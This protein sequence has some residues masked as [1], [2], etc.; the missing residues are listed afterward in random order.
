MSVGKGSRQARVS[1]RTKS[2]QGKYQRNTIVNGKSFMKG[3]GR[4][5]HS[6][7]KTRLQEGSQQSEKAR[8]TPDLPLPRSRQSTA[9]SPKTGDDASPPPSAGDKR[10]TAVPPDDADCDTVRAKKPC[11]SSSSFLASPQAES[12][13]SREQMGDPVSSAAETE[14]ELMFKKAIR[15]Y[16][17]MTLLDIPS[18]YPRPLYRPF[19]KRNLLYMRKSKQSS[20]KDS[21]E[22]PLLCDLPERTSCKPKLLPGTK[23]EHVSRLVEGI[24]RRN[25]WKQDE[26]MTLDAAVGLDSTQS[27]SNNAKQE[28]SSALNISKPSDKQMNSDHPT[29]VMRFIDIRNK[30]LPGNRHAMITVYTAQETDGVFSEI[31][32]LPSATVQ[33][34][35]NVRSNLVSIDLPHSIGC[36]CSGEKERYDYVILRV[37]FSGEEDAKIS[38]GRTLRSVPSR[39]AEKAEVK[40][41]RRSSN[42]YAP[43]KYNKEDIVT[44]YG[45]RCIS[46]LGDGHINGVI[47]GDGSINLVPEAALRCRNNWRRDRSLTKKLIDLGKKMHMGPFVRMSIVQDSGGETSSSE[48]DDD[49]TRSCS[50]RAES[51]DSF[52][53]VRS[54]FSRQ[55]SV[56]S[57]IE[58]TIVSAVSD[59]FEQF[60]KARYKHEMSLDFPP[61]IC[62]RFIMRYNEEP[63]TSFPENKLPSVPDEPPCLSA[64]APSPVQTNGS[65][66]P[67]KEE[68]DASS[69]KLSPTRSKKPKFRLDPPRRDSLPDMIDSYAKSYTKCTKLPPPRSIARDDRITVPEL[70]YE[71]YPAPDGNCVITRFLSPSNMCF[72][73]LGTFPDMFALLLHM[74]TCYPRLDIVYKG[75]IRQTAVINSSAPV[76]V[77]V[78]VRENFDG[79]FE[80][81]MIRQYVN[82]RNRGV[83]QRC[84]PSDRLT[85]LV[86][87]SEARAIRRMRKD[88]S[89]FFTSADREKRALKGNNAAYF[90]FRSRHPLMNPTQISTK[91]TDQE[92]LRE[93]IIRQIEDFLDL[94]RTE[95]DFMTMW[96]IFLLNLNHK[97]LGRCHMYR[98]CRLFLQKHRQDLISKNLQSAWV[99]HLTAFYEKEALDSDEVYDLIMRLGENY[100]PERDVCHVV[101]STKVRLEA[102]ANS[103][104]REPPSWQR[105]PVLG[106]K[107][108]I[109][110]SASSARLSSVEPSSDNE[111]MFKKFMNDPPTEER[112]SSSYSGEEPARQCSSRRQRESDCS[113]YLTNPRATQPPRW[114]AFAE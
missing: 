17:Y 54:H 100:D 108:S 60:M 16:R 6:P 68:P 19:L 85:Y 63:N 4:F 23:R 2:L 104:K 31:Q 14:Y 58:E 29:S 27:S 1:L 77:D 48:E 73:C 56:V 72:F 74:R 53:G 96:N 49:E 11:Q 109:L 12:A 24:Y 50:S 103:V 44:M 9:S 3:R 42:F 22:L 34:Q 81:P 5:S 47:Y 21:D 87:K 71:N 67:L 90:G 64:L 107:T 78:F 79:S 89:I 30:E 26:Q 7:Y 83:P 94:S 110:R 40:V 101:H 102:A 70:H 20:S 52:R 80:G 105:D 66:S 59:G 41:T 112:R 91:Q 93:F 46:S 98:S 106:P 8:Y 18:G 45:A 113:K 35:V 55:S 61:Q 15:L 37:C 75:D 57:S 36:L 95:K 111:E 84:M 39:Q 32:R 62:Y 82:A 51:L 76:Y 10:R 97:P 33:M 86:Y 25:K 92:W 69:S 43:R 65:A 13:F 99:F 28:S 88:L 114:L 38:G